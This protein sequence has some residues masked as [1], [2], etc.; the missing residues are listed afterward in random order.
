MLKR[1]RRRKMLKRL[2]K[3]FV[4]GLLFFIPAVVTLY[5]FYAA[6]VSLDK[7]LEVTVPGL[8][9]LITVVFITLLGFLASNFFTGWLFKGI[10]WLFEYIPMV[11]ILYRG[12]KD[13]TRSLVG[14]KKTFT[15]PVLVSPSEDS[16]I[17]LVGFVSDES[18]SENGLRDLVAVYLP[19]AYNFAGNLVLVPK[20]RI[21]PIDAEG[22]EVLAFVLS[23][24]MAG[25]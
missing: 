18:M 2:S 7:M 25:E 5:L 21:T 8:G 16:E 23:G 10:D 19:Q 22:S 3:Y 6:F 15:H 17:R 4:R 14:E 13:I 20:E 1:F 11:K 9:L 12:I 24:G